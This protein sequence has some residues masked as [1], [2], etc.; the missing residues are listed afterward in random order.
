MIYEFP[1]PGIIDTKNIYSTFTKKKHVA[2]ENIPKIKKINRQRK[3]LKDS[4]RYL[5][6]LKPGEVPPYNL[7]DE[8]LSYAETSG[9]LDSL[10]E[11]NYHITKNWKWTPCLT[12]TKLL[13]YSQT[14]KYGKSGEILMSRY[15]AFAAC[16]KMVK[17]DIGFIKQNLLYRNE[18]DIYGD[19][20]Y[21]CLMK[22]APVVNKL[23]DAIQK[24]LKAHVKAWMVLKKCY[25]CSGPFFKNL[26]TYSNKYIENTAAGMEMALLITKI[27]TNMLYIEYL[28]LQGN[29]EEMGKYAKTIVTQAFLVENLI[30]SNEF[31]VSQ[32]LCEFILICQRLYKA[33]AL[34]SLFFPYMIKL[35]TNSF[36]DGEDV[37]IL[38]GG[39]VSFIY[40]IG[41]LHRDILN[42]PGFKSSPLFGIVSLYFK[43]LLV[44]KSLEV[45]KAYN[46]IFNEYHYEDFHFEKME[47]IDYISRAVGDDNQNQ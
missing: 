4:L 17:V 13:K 33:I 8:A 22:K 23:E 14:I 9:E 1:L 35:Q 42:L 32:N 3:S 38:A 6:N 11:R 19:L 39:C 47:E 24:V 7:V 36:C 43:D 30:K 34:W 5:N 15:A 21:S 31:Y 10:F 2:R 46:D 28:R 44:Q 16:F 45:S 26:S 37:N 40:H 20:T 29:Y 25:D 18:V 12:P 41:E 27:N